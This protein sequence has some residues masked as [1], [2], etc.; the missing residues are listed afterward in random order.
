MPNRGAVFTQA[1][2]VASMQNSMLASTQ[3]HGTGSFTTTDNIK[4]AIGDGDDEAQLHARGLFG[5]VFGGGKSKQIA[6]QKQAEF[7]SFKLSM[8]ELYQ[9]DKLAFDQQLETTREA[10]TNAARK[11]LDLR[12]E[13]QYQSRVWKPFNKKSRTTYFDSIRDEKGA[14]QNE[15]IVKQQLEYMDGLKKPQVIEA[16]EN[17]SV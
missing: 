16:L 10:R 4:R 11:R 7:E 1:A 2:N 5:N 12:S 3:H 14:L 17:S 15:R 6:A 9:Q 13:R 8:S